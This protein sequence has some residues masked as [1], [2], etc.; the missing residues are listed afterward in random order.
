MVTADFSS[1][2]LILIAAVCPY[3]S[4]P[5]FVPCVGCLVAREPKRLLECVERRKRGETD[6]PEETGKDEGK[7]TDREIDM[8]RERESKAQFK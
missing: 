7:Q 3:M 4:A 2:R 1:Y 8:E 5:V 6:V